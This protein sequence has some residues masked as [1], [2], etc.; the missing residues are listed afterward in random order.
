MSDPDAD[1][2]WK[3][4]EQWLFHAV[5]DRRTATVCLAADPP[6]LDSASFHCQQA[7][8]KLLKGALVWASISFGKTHDLSDLGDKLCK[9]YPEFSELV[10]GMEMWTTWN[11]AYRYPMDDSADVLP[12]LET[13]SSAL[14]TIDRL[15]DKV[16]EFRRNTP[17]TIATS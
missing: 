13:L 3:S 5:S 8:E 6:L 7:A 11:I 14:V 16:I 2:A 1:E 12:S 15:V 17:R 4:V 10:A 9:V